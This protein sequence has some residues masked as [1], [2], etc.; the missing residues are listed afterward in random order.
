MDPDFAQRRRVFVAAAITAVAVP[1][2][3]MLDRG[4]DADTPPVGTLVGT[5]PGAAAQAAPAEPT[6]RSDPVDSHV[7]TILGTTPTG[8]LDGTV[9]P[10]DADPPIIAYPPPP[11]TLTGDA[12]FSDQISAVT[13]CI[14]A[15]APNG[16]T[17]TLTNLDNGRSVKCRAANVAGREPTARPLAIVHP[18]T[19]AVIGD[20]TA[21][22]VPVEISW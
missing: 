16:A 13:T 1:A 19:F 12:T 9:P 15:E 10:G 18:D 22:P 11:D 4:G 17:V 6:D 7:A 8:Y 3:F 5:V 14:I 21:A 2:M 20:I